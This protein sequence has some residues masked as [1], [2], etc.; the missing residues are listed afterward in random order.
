MHQNAAE[1]GNHS[2][3]AKGHH[4]LAVGST[5]GGGGCHRL[6]VVAAKTVV[7]L[8]FPGCVVFL[9]AFSYSCAIFRFDMRICL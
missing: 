3:V 4:G 8:A 6:T 5:A 2:R 7:V 1:R 9:R